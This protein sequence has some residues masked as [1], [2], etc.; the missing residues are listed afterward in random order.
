MLVPKRLSLIHLLCPQDSAADSEVKN[1]ELNRAVEELNKL[2]KEA[3]N[4]LNNFHFF[5]VNY[6]I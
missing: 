6:E 3:V 4:G 1:A 2:L 5:A